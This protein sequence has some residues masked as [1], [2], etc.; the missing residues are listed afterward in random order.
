MQGSDHI[1]YGK[2]HVLESPH[3]FENDYVMKG[4]HSIILPDDLMR[5]CVNIAKQMAP[6]DTGNLAEAIRG[7]RKGISKA[8][9]F[10]VVYPFREANYVYALEFGTPKTPQHVGFIRNQ[11]VGLIVSTIEG[12]FNQNLDL[13]GADDAQWFFY[14][15]AYNKGFGSSYS[16]HYIGRS[17]HFNADTKNRLQRRVK[18]ISQ[19]NKMFYYKRQNTSIRNDSVVQKFH[20][21]MEIQRRRRS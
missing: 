5:T 17:R 20:E 3:N 19:Y 6:F 21:H 12:Y 8:K 14:K 13:S 4:D 1:V 2:Y 11:T 9:E 16:K 10:S 15:L 7:E 18:S